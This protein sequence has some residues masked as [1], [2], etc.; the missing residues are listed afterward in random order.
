MNFKLKFQ[1]SQSKGFNFKLNL[2]DMRQDVEIGIGGFGLHLICSNGQ[3]YLI[4]RRG[5]LS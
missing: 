4:I 1:V 5:Y 3:K 2:A